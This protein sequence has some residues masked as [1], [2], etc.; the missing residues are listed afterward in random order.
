MAAGASADVSLMGGHPVLDFVNTVAWR[1]DPARRAERVTG[2]T[3]WARWAVTAGLLTPPQSAALQETLAAAETEETQRQL[4]ALH[5]L[6]A[7]LWPVLDALTDG[8]TPP[9]HEWNGLRRAILLAHES[10]ELP[11]RRSRCAGSPARTGSPTWGTRSPSRPKDSSPTPAS[12]GSG[13]AEGPAADGSS[14]TAAAA[15]PGDG[16]AQA[17]AVTATA[18]A[19][20]TPAPS[21]RRDRRGGRSAS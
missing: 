8:E 3:A 9:P 17:T 5:H 13:A 11:M 21:R 6:R 14:S 16:A 20:T 10:A 4:A 19:A 15:A 18:P 1:T 2:A 12:I 7:L